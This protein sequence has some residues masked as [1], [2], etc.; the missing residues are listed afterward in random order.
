[1][2]RGQVLNLPTTY[3]YSTIFRCCLVSITRRACGKLATLDAFALYYASK[4]TFSL[5]ASKQNVLLLFCL[6]AL[7]IEPYLY[8]MY[9][10]S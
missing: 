2:F 4:G 9:D 7:K 3:L 1:M 8:E 6:S 5:E 10:K